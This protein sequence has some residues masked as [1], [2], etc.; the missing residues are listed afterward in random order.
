VRVV[1]DFAG[2]EH[3]TV[4]KLSARL[5]RVVDGA[6][7]A[8]AETKL[9]SQVYEEPSRGVAIVRLLDGC[10]EPA[11]VAAGEDASDLVLEVEAF[12]ED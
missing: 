1:D 9:A 12:L 8:V 11:A 2:Q 7:D 10:D 4:R 5:I 6:V 3:L